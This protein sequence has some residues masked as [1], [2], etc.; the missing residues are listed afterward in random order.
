MFED[1]NFYIYL[2]QIELGPVVESRT[3]EATWV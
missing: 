1:A 2:D 3:L